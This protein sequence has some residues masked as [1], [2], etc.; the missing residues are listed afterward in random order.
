MHRISS[1]SEDY[2]EGDVMLVEQPEAPVLFLSSATTDITS[3]SSSLKL[4]ENQYWK[5]RIRAL[6]L[7]E[8][9]NNAQIDHY[10]NTTAI[11]SKIIIVR[12]LGGINHW[13]YGLDQLV[14]WKQLSN[15]RKLIIIS[16]TQDNEKELNKLSSESLNIVNNISELFRVG[17]IKNI[18]LILNLLKNLLNDYK[19]DLNNYLVYKYD[20]INKYEWNEDKG[21]KIGLIF[22]NSQFKAN[23]TD[24]AYKIIE[25]LR[26]NKFSPKAIFVSSLQEKNNQKEIIDIYKNENVEAIITTTSFS[27]INS[28]DASF[29]THMWDEINVPVFQ[30][31]ISTESKKKWEKSHLGMN[32]IDLTM[33]IVM[34]EIDG[35]ITTRPCAFKEISDSKDSL[36]TPIKYLSANSE[37]IEWSIKYIYNWINLKKI[38]NKDKKVVIM[39]A[40][41]PVRNGRIANGVGLDTPESLYNIIIWLKQNN[42]YLGE[43]DIPK[44]SKEI[45][46][47]I[48][49]KRTNDPE[50]IYKIPLDYISIEDYMYY[51]Q[52]ID[53]SS[54]EK[55]IESWG[56]PENAI[57]LEKNNFPIHGIKL[58]NISILIQPS[59][60]YENDN[61]VDL[62]SPKLPPPHRYIAQYLWVE[63]ILNCNAIIHLGKHGSLEWLPGKGIGLSSKCFPHIALPPIPNI[64]P[65]IVNDPGEGSQA[66]RRTQAVIIDHL[67]PPLGR[68]GLY[69]NMLRLESLLNEY[70]DSKTLKSNRIEVIKEDIIDI[71][72]KES[73]LFS[74]HILN[75]NKLNNI[76]FDSL[77]EQT[78]SFLCEIKESQIRIGLHVLGKI[79]NNNN[80]TQLVKSIA[81]SPIGNYKG[82]TQLIA[83]SLDFS[84]DPWTDDEK[85]TL[86]KKDENTFLKIQKRL[87]RKKGEVIDYIENQASLIV[88]YLLISNKKQEKY[89]K[90][91]QIILNK[92]HPNLHDMIKS[93]NNTYTKFI[94][95]QIINRINISANN[96]KNSLLKALDGGRIYSGP[97]GSPTRACIDVLPTG[98]NFYSVDIRGLP[99]QAAWDLGKRSAKQ[100]LDIYNLEKGEELT[101]IAISVWATSTMRNGGEDIA[102]ILALMGIQPIWE[103]STRRLIDIEVIPL[104]VLERPRVEVITRISGLFRDSFPQLIELLYS[105]QLKLANLDEPED[106]NAYTKLNCDGNIIKRIF[107]SA[108]G[109]YGAGLQELISNSNWEDK[110]DLVDSYLNWSKWS[111]KGSTNPESSKRELKDSLKKVQVVLHNQDNKEHDI[112]DSDDYYQF[113]GGLSASV[114]RYSGK[115]PYMIVSDHSR[116]ARPRIN[117]LEKEIDQV[118]RNRLLNPKWI[119]GIKNHGYKGAFEISASIDY[120]FG[121]DSTTDVVSDWIYKSIYT[122][123]I[124]NDNNRNF[125]SNENPWVLRD[126]SERLL[127]S[128]NRGLWKENDNA[129]INDL[130]RIVNI[131]ESIIE[132][133]HN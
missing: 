77:L 68:S 129:V 105:A 6:C 14:K 89:K 88:N 48:L 130:K 124:K 84:I 56:E 66:K 73:F 133:Y 50:S 98:K 125:I 47:M 40:N 59:R 72:N 1:Q 118:V 115:K 96:E 19:I 109:S 65:F 92:I 5:G 113:H 34:P 15:D 75:F 22:Y 64:Y 21:I 123:F 46:N 38:K 79:P 62:H 27:I 10:L 55:I 82:I 63:K 54:K 58:G 45:M 42:Y 2:Q 28:L 131:S 111:Y 132:N 107:G 53:R 69:G 128:Y 117:T 100:I 106:S 23:D 93:D 13:S 57:E 108:P 97:S 35:R 12:L 87:P 120:L 61:L 95:K 29:D 7:N 85:E 16:G 76:E 91:L 104:S 122:T 31:L 74:R 24:Y 112:L 11:N 26:L 99:T 126:I 70:Y 4:K 90:D 78:D 49:N 32:P 116:H 9:S 17:G 83:S 121:Y 51:W 71:L 103:Y 94:Q 25:L 67:T 30:L 102:Q 18:S 81:R 119:E 20:N 60:G 44:T 33:Q 127:E 114:E 39:L 101:N 43:V 41:Y 3:I 86:S 37:L 80:L 8:L 52:N 36:S 110:S